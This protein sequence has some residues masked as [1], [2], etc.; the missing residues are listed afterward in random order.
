MLHIF[1]S[2]SY[3][4][5]SSIQRHQKHTLA[6]HKNQRTT[7]LPSENC[8]YHERN[9]T[10]THILLNHST[11]AEK[12]E[13]ISRHKSTKQ[14]TIGKTEDLQKTTCRTISP[15]STDEQQLQQKRTT[16]KPRNT[17]VDHT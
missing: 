11:K 7:Y 12:I 17:T 15:T 3:E 10:T 14:H 6:F 16:F 1:R 9:K 13:L 5:L 2:N 8:K 4:P